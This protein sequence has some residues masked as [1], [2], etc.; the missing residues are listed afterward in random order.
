MPVHLVGKT[1]SRPSDQG[2]WGGM[3]VSVA[4]ISFE[5]LRVCMVTKAAASS[6]VHLWLTHARGISVAIR[7]RYAIRRAASMGESKRLRTARSIKAAT[8]CEQNIKFKL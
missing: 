6:F 2:F 3:N 1:S 8:I 4:L 5:F 7:S